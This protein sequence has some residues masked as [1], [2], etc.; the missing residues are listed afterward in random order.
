[1]L[2]LNFIVL[3]IGTGMY[4]NHYL[5]IILVLTI[6]VFVNGCVDFNKVYKN[7]K[8]NSSNYKNITYI[9]SN[10]TENSTDTNE[11]NSKPS[12]KIVIEVNSFYK[13][14]EVVDHQFSNRTNTLY[15]KIS[16]RGKSKTLTTFNY[17]ITSFIPNEIRVY[18]NDDYYKLEVS[19]T[20]N[21][22]HISL[23]IISNSSLCCGAISSKLNCDNPYTLSLRMIFRTGGIV[24]NAWSYDDSTRTLNIYFERGK[25]VTPVI[26][27]K[28]YSI[29]VCEVPNKIVIHINGVQYTIR[30]ITCKDHTCFVFFEEIPK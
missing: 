1:M 20:N 27:I 15:L 3:L 6:I 2:Y 4:M 8:V 29:K 23:T 24:C 9:K 12:G 5:I 25:Y 21:T 16:G 18:V 17:S 14:V 10:M 28:N 7:T 30:N 13:D 22:I 26:T 11:N 19:P